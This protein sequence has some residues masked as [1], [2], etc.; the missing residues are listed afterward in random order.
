MIDP[1][2]CDGMV[3]NC[4]NQPYDCPDDSVF[5]ETRVGLCCVEYSCQ[6]PDISC[7]LLMESVKEVMPHPYYRG[8]DYPG[9]C[10]P[11]YTFEGTHS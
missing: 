9:R 7:P 8:G 6:C 4:P 11:E 1:T 5:I 10:C 2:L 3:C